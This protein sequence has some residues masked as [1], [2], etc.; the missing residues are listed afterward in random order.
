MTASS[1]A[2]WAGA[3]RP[4]AGPTGPEFIPSM[5]WH[6]PKRHSRVGSQ[7]IRQ[8]F[9]I[10]ATFLSGEGPYF[11]ETVLRVM[12]NL[13]PVF[14]SRTVLAASTAFRSRYRAH[15]RFDPPI[16]IRDCQ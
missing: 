5:S 10:P 13:R 11:R 4:L 14:P 9:L 12:K 15:E 6:E 2:R 7:I 3:H 16:E 8:L 1:P